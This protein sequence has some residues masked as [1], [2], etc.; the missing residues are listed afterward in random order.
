MPYVNEDGRVGVA[1]SG[2]TTVGELTFAFQQLISEYLTKEG[3]SYQQIAEC[4]GALEGCKADFIERIVKP[5]E[6]RKRVENSDVW[7]GKMLREAAITPVTD[8][9]LGDM[10]R[11]NTITPDEVEQ[12]RAEAVAVA[13]A[14]ARKGYTSDQVIKDHGGK[15]YLPAGNQPSASIPINAFV[16]ED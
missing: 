5:Y 14:K 16:D 7:P 11:R 1:Q 10:R 12:R 13:Q 3:L 8:T 2:P 15:D 6:V 9:T 4:L